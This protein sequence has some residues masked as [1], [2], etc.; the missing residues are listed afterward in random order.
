MLFGA[1]GKAWEPEPSLGS[2]SYLREGQGGTGWTEE[3]QSCRVLAYWSFAHGN[4]LSGLHMPGP[5]EQM[6]GRVG[7][8]TQ[9]AQALPGDPATPGLTPHRT[10]Y[11]FR[12]WTF[13]LFFK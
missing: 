6:E 3:G 13:D 8:G 11:T 2:V 12:L 5:T 1:C 7:T 10:F 4:E 9:L